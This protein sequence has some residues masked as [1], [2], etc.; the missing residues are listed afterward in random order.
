[1][2]QPKELTPI[3]VA[4]Q[5]LDRVEYIGT[6]EYVVQMIIN[7]NPHSNPLNG[8]EVVS[9]MDFWIKVKKCL[10]SKWNIS[11]TYYKH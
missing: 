1:M 10:I 9:T 2:K 7:S 11:Q 4:N 8:E 5:I 3:M 6:A